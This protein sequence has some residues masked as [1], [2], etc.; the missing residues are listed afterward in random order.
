MIIYCIT[1]MS[2]KSFF[3]CFSRLTNIHFII[4]IICNFIYKHFSHLNI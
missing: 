1:Y 2:S 4:N 3:N